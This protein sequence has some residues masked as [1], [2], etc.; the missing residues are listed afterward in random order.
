MKDSRGTSIL[1]VDAQALFRDGLRGILSTQDD[2]V[3]VGEAGDSAQAVAL[4]T[5]TQPHVILL[6]NDT[7]GN[8]IIT[9][10]RLICGRSPASAVVILSAFEEP[11]Q[12]RGLLAAGIRGYLPKDTTSQGLLSTVQSV[13]ANGER[14]VLSVSRHSLDFMAD[15][16]ANGRVLSEREQQILV[17][18]AHAL[19][20]RQI[21]IRL[22]LTEATVKRHL[23]NIF[24]KLGAVSR[25]DAVNK[26]MA[27]SLI[28]AGPT[29]TPTSPQR[30]GTG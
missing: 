29:S 6:D 10:V 7:P 3:V 9:T 21:A 19:S 16:A 18:T 20:N 30:D 28:P 26:A 27:W 13:R 2:L 11:V 24:A 14:V 4:A 1:V 17:L 23:R 5:E 25:I 8:D 22:S 15:P 12:L